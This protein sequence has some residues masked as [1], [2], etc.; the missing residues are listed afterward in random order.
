MSHR[1]RVRAPQG[2]AGGQSEGSHGQNYPTSATRWW[3]WGA[4][5]GRGVPRERGAVAG[6]GAHASERARASREKRGGRWGREGGEKGGS[7]AVRKF[8]SGRTRNANKGQKRKEAIQSTEIAEKRWRGESEGGARWGESA[9]PKMAGVV[10]IARCRGHCI[11]FR[12]RIPPLQVAPI[13]T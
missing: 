6:R 5:A 12:S 8:E 3:W 4:V 13:I 11:A 1:S 7:K 2:V 10:H 9:T